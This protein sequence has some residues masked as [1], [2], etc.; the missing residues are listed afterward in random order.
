MTPPECHD[1]ELDGVGISGWV[2]VLYH[3]VLAVVAL[4]R[5]DPGGPLRE[6]LISRRDTGFPSF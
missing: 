6:H 4:L 1:Y 3:L 2:L 5:A